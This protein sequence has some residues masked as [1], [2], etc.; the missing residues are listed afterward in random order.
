[1]SILI[2]YRRIAGVYVVWSLSL[3]PPSAAPAQQP[4]GM[5]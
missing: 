2:H 5:V 3:V 1:M 4:Y